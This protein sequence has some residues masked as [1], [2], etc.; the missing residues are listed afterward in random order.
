LTTFQSDETQ[1]DEARLAAMS[2]SGEDSIEKVDL[3]LETAL[4][5]L[6]RENPL[7]LIELSSE[8]C[9]MSQRLHYPQGEANS[10]LW[11]GAAQ[12]YMSD[13][14]R[15]LSTLLEA[16]TNFAHLDDPTG[17]A[18]VGVFIGSVY[19]SLGDQDQAF[20]ESIEAAE[21]FHRARDPF[22]ESLARLSL[23]MTSFEI[24]DLEGTMKQS[25]TILELMKSDPES[26]IRGRALQ[27]IGVV[28][29]R[30]GNHREA[31]EHCL[32]SLKVCRTSGYRMGEARALHDLASAHERL[33]N[34][35][36]AFQCYS[37]SLSI[38]REIHQREAQSTTLISLGNLF[39]QEDSER[40]IAYLEEA[41]A[42]ATETGIKTRI[43]Q[44]H[45]ALSE[46]Y[47]GRKDLA[48]AIKHLKL[49]QL[50]QEQVF[51]EKSKLHAY[52]LRVRFE[53]EKR[54]REAEIARLKE[55][56]EEGVALGSYRM[57]ERLG[58]GGM[59]EVWRGQHRLLARAAAVKVI[60]AGDPNRPEHKELAQRFEREARVTANLRSPHTVQLYDFGISESGAFYYVMEL[61]EGMDLKIM[62]EKH[63]PLEPERAVMLLRQACRSL[64]EA[65]ERG[66]VHRDIKPANLYVS[67]LGTEYDF[68]KVLDFG[69]VKA[70]PDEDTAQLTL[71]DVFLGT[72]AFL[73]PELIHR[74]QSVDAR[75]D[76][77]SL[78]CTAFWMLTGRCV[79][80]AGTAAEMLV[81]HMHSPP[82]RLSDI[83]E[84]EIPKHLEE[85]VLQC[86]EK[87]PD[88]R[89]KSAMHLWELL[90]EIQLRS[91]WT[92]DRALE[93]WKRHDPSK[94][95]R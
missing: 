68:L 54:E 87:N 85:I 4:H 32:Q 25:K 13:L 36:K 93:W 14:E 29:S 65:H 19:R 7:K 80:Q 46:V 5:L 44:A 11:L 72:P 92:Q 48:G 31:F 95:I 84:L 60:R 15:A 27:M 18:K 77:Y 74:K 89:P 90:G 66:L 10:Q 6:G 49:Y 94:T 61:L 38:R 42:I 51:E 63:G 16:K 76:L 37:E 70:E 39:K 28:H 8:A 59:G 47:E 78:G 22:W 71:P 62:V 12:W 17:R 81:H 20:L 26:W 50:I 3:L 1:S 52:N 30:T 24:A 58:S 23:A 86:L 41:L 45:R 57:V 53:A 34:R 88:H 67:N 35:E 91:E 40:A 69:M 43:S 75:A 56:L 33:G 21:F 55:T 64:A 73:P 83:S 2:Q 82:P 9:A 79:F